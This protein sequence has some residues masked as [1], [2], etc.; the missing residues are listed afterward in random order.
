MTDAQRKRLRQRVLKELAETPI[1]TMACKKAGLPRATFYRWRS[2][3]EDFEIESDIAL[4]Q[5]RERI[6]DLAESRLIRGVDQGELPF[7]RYWLSHNHHS[8]VKHKQMPLPYVTQ[9]VRRPRLWL[10]FWS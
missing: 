6:N 7:L 5:G 2:E 10:R 1:V 3:D 4:A 9:G 8:Y